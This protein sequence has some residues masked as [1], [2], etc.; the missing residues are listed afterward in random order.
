MVCSIQ[1]FPLLDGYRGSPPTDLTAIEHLLLRVSWLVDEVPQIAEMDLNP[2]KV[3]EPGH[4]LAT[5]DAR[6]YV[7]DR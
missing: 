4:G 6:V 7:R 1:G 3:F 5:V 2:V